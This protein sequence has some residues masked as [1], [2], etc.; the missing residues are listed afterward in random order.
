[1]CEW[2]DGTA[3]KGTWKQGM[4]CGQGTLSRPDGYV[5][6]GEWQADAQHGQGCCRYDD[7]SRC[8]HAIV[9]GALSAVG[10]RFSRML[11]IL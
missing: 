2:V 8:A 6:E 1:M 11:K 7:G 5:Y 4:R 3:Y 9:S 10:T